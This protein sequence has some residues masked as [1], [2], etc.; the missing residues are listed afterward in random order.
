MCEGVRQRLRSFPHI[1]LY[2]A[3]LTC[4]LY[5][6]GVISK[7]ELR[8]LV[9]SRGFYV[10]DSDAKLVVDKMDK[11]RDGVVSYSEFREELEPKSYSFYRR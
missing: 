2:S 9:D 7:D 6:D 5:N 11:D 8:R 10:S 4:D 1:D 3:F